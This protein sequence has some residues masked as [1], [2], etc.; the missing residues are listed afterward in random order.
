MAARKKETEFNAYSSMPSKKAVETIKEP[1]QK[2]D[3]K[4]Y[5]EEFFGGVTGRLVCS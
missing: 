4:N 2:G 5:E 1:L 3:N